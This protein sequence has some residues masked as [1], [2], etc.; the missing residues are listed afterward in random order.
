MDF[1]SGADTVQCRLAHVTAA[2]TAKSVLAEDMRK[3]HCGHSGLKSNVL[4]DVNDEML[5]IEIQC[6]DF[7]KLTMG[8]C[9]GPNQVYEI[10]EQCEAVCTQLPAGKLAELDRRT[11]SRRCRRANAYKALRTT[12]PAEVAGSCSDASPVPALCGAGRCETYCALAA[13]SGCTAQF[14]QQFGTTDPTEKCKMNCRALS[15][16]GNDVNYSIAAA[17]TR[18]SPLSCRGLHAARALAATVAGKPITAGTCE[19]A[20]GLPAPGGLPTACQ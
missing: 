19:A 18:G 1:E 13:K 20:M 2:A 12:E 5:G 11:D 16:T 14:A 6:A 7:C 10:N 8:V 3:V 4:C 9:Q 17:S 15:D